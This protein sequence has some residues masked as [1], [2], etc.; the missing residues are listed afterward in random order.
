MG[1]SKIS[2]GPLASLVATLLAW[3]ASVFLVHGTALRSWWLSDDTQVLA[4]AV[5][6]TPWSLLFSP[7][8]WSTLSTSSFTPLVTMSFQADLAI[9][10]MRPA[11]FYAHQLL[12]VGTSI[13][14]FFL[15]LRRFAA[16]AESA[17]AA[18]LLL[19]SPVTAVV[20]HSLMLRHYAEGL[21]FS[22]VA[23]HFFDR[24]CD[25]ENSR[26]RMTLMLAG[27]SFAYLVAILAKEFYIPLPVLCLL[28]CVLRRVDLWGAVLRLVPVGLTTI[29]ALSWRLKMLGSVGGYS[30]TSVQVDVPRNLRA[31][32]LAS[33]GKSAS[34]GFATLSIAVVIL[35]L[36]ASTRPLRALACAVA[37]AIFTLPPLLG[38]GNV[39]EARYA[40]VASVVLAA[41]LAGAVSLWT[42]REIAISLL[43][44]CAVLLTLASITMQ[45]AMSDASRP[46]IAEGKYVFEGAG[47]APALL[48]HSPP[49]YL[50]GMTWLR[51]HYE[52]RGRGPRF[53]F[54]TIPVA[55]GEV[56]ADEVISVADDGSARPL[57]AEELQ[58]AIAD[59]DRLRR[60]LPLRVEASKAR[61]IFTWNFGPEPASQWTFVTHPQNATFIIPASGSRRVPE[62]Y[63]REWFR[64]RRDLPDGT[65]TISDV[66]EVP[67]EGKKVSWSRP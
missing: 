62:P 23:L 21:L 61:H 17:V 14:L 13:A 59:R 63:E 26:L 57:T 41:A 49:W 1:R 32:L 6:E 56:R 60:D 51:D 58:A 5:R 4:Q 66:L 7:A 22:L 19:V 10:G 52:H 53:F 15:L 33:F 45:H 8:G 35:V 12:A 30:D 44:G 25:R 46:M 42:N 3:N 20:A 31:L 47:N 24:A 37:A 64:V 18:T 50:A 9:A 43:A 36:G 48:A 29:V 65:W 28:I 39:V 55:T 54:T 16:V 11:F 38:T 40:F 34:V 27:A 2:R 67:S